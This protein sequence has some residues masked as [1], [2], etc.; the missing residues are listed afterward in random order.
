MAVRDCGGI[1]GQDRCFTTQCHK[2]VYKLG[3]KVCPGTKLQVKHYSSKILKKLSS[4]H[5]RC[6]L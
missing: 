5:R 1:L 4:E 2:P 3:L 6:K